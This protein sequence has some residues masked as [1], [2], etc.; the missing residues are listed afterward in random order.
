MPMVNSHLQAASICT[1]SHTY[2]HP[3][4]TISADS[5]SAFKNSHAGGYK[6]AIL[7]ANPFPLTEHADISNIEARLRIIK[8]HGNIM[9]GLGIPDKIKSK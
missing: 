1:F 9:I 4:I 2:K 5:H 6:L 8:S 7:S 3:Y